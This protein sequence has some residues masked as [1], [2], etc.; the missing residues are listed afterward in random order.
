MRKF[1]TLLTAVLF[2]FTAYSQNSVKLNG[3]NNPHFYGEN[4]KDSPKNLCDHSNPS[5]AFE[6]GYNCSS[7]SDYRLA[8]DFIVSADENFIL[9]QITAYIFSH[10]AISSVSALYYSDD[11][12]MPGTEIGNQLSIVPT[13]QVIIGDNFGYDL[14]EVVLDLTGFEFSGQSGSETTYWIELIVTND[15]AAADIYWEVTSAST[16]GNESAQVLALGD[17]WTYTAGFD[18][19]YTFSGDCVPFCGSNNL[20]DAFENAYNCGVNSTYSTANDFLI[21]A[22]EKFI[23]EQIEARIWTSSGNTIESVEIQYYEDDAGFPGNEIGSETI[24]PT[25]QENLSIHPFGSYDVHRTILDVTPFTFLGQTGGSTTYWIELTIEDNL[26]SETY[27]GITSLNSVGNDFAFQNGTDPWYYGSSGYD[28]IY[29]FYGQCDLMNTDAEILTFSIPD[30]VSSTVNDGTSTVQVYM[31]NGTDLS[32]L[33]ADFSI[34]DFANAD[35]G[36]TPQVSGTTANDFT[37]G[38]LVYTVTAENGTTRDWTVSV[39]YNVSINAIENNSVKLYPNPNNGQFSIDLS[40]MG[41]IETD[42]QVVNIQGQII[43]EYNNVNSTIFNI[44]LND[45][46]QGLYYVRIVSEKETILKKVSINK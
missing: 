14:Y 3:E 28:G 26:G 27:W 21:E 5:N 44:N 16:V 46:S 41:N 37:S 39:D 15:D 6:N 31:Q 9:S 45:L 30:Q 13:S 10:S 22:D 23:L 2:L 8:N 20:I 11:A 17:P 12:G 35:V 43:A 38:P 19:V 33:V 7:N 36:G 24:A 42:I 40:T 18:G 32:A 29:V 25:S 1:I 34:S 4:T